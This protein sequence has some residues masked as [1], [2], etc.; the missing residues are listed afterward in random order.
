MIETT[1]VEYKEVSPKDPVM[2]VG[3]PGIGLIG[4]LVVDHLISELKAEKIMEIFSPHLPPQVTV[5]ADGTTKLVSNEIYFLKG[6]DKTP[7]LLL[8]VGDHQSAT[9]EG[10]YELAGIYLD[11]AEKFQTKRIYTLGGYGTGKLMDVPHVLYATNNPDIIEEI[12]SYGPTFTEGELSGGIIGASGLILGLGE[13]RGMEAVC[14]MGETSGYLVDPKSAQAVLSVLS[15]ALN[16]EVDTKELEARAQEIEKIITK[17]KE[18][19][20]TQLPKEYGAEDKYIG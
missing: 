9:N 3:L 5:N 10:H 14:I 2:I 11:I 7:D 8:L 17:I 6:N 18:M 12:K 13:L 15:K 1:V 19:E 4:K 20:E 16:F